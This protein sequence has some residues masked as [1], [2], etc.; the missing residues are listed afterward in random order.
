MND[1]KTLFKMR[2]WQYNFLSNEALMRKY[3][4][5]HA[6]AFECLYL[7]NKTQLLNFI[8]RQCHNTSIAEELV[9]DTW[10]AVITQASSYQEKAKFT[11]WLF[12]IAHNRLIDHW[13][14]HGN[15]AA[16]LI[17]EI[18]QQLLSKSH[19]VSDPVI[20]VEDISRQLSSLSVE[21]MEVVLL[22]IEGFS[23]LEIAEITNS[24]PETVKS[25][26]RYATKRLRTSMELSV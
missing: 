4:Q 23:H 1:R 22:R 17:D 10:M 11:T 14:K 12:R 5:G 16:I 21:Q 7:R 8:K 6:D 19:E 3:S 25:R 20:E 13:R 9:H 24:K 18:G 2:K 26:L 15:S